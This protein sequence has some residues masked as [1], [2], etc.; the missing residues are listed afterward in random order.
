MSVYTVES[1][2]TQPGGSSGGPRMIQRFAQWTMIHIQAVT[3]ATRF[4]RDQNTLQQ[5]A[6]PNAVGQGL[7]IGPP[8]SDATIHSM[9]W[10]GELW[11]VGDTTQ[12][13]FDLEVMQ[14]PNGPLMSAGVTDVESGRRKQYDRG[15]AE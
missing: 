2:S 9:W 15:S 7:K 8:A 5:P 12:S 14:V 4:C 13:Q 3:G 6:Q 1:T 11:A 10:F